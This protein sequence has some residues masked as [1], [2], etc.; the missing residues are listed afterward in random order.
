MKKYIYTFIYIFIFFPIFVILTKKKGYSLNLKERFSIGLNKGY[1]KTVWFH[2]ASVGELNLVKPLIEDIKLRESIV[3]T[4]FSPRGI[5]Y[6]KKNFPYAEIYPVPFDIPI[7]IKRFI[8]I[9]NPKSLF[10]VEE[11]YWYSL[12]TVSSRYI[13][14]VS[15]NSRVSEKSYNFY[16]RFYLFY[17][18]IFNS[19]DRYLVRSTKDLNLLS[20]LIEN[21]NKLILCG[22]LKFLSSQIK[23]E[24]NLNTLG[25]KVIVLGSSHNPEEELV[26]E[27]FKNLKKDIKNLALIIAPRH[28]E[29][30][31]EIEELIL[32]R[33]L[34]YNLRTNSKSLEKDVY[35]LNTIGELGGI[36]K[37]ADVVILGGTFANIGGHNILEPAM[38]NKPVIVGKHIHKIEENF[39]YLNKLGIAFQ[40]KSKTDLEKKL[41]ELLNTNYELK[42]NLID[43]S[44]KIFNCYKKFI[45]FYE[46][47]L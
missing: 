12:I 27:I 8:K 1:K 11:E 32:K 35:I 10:I 30:V 40:T 21:K 22:D 38:F 26:L 5:E 4:V 29:R 16:K 2:C 28:L 14:V 47:H 25:K 46:F 44:K 39:K 17:K 15:I 18:D 42:T 33:G 9:L 3:I 19:I 36:Y 23:R 45:R 37:Y 7:L 41:K 13:N 24:V 20:N 43:L 6:A 31:K 34:S